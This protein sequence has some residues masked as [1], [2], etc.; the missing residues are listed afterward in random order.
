MASISAPMIPTMRCG[1][2]RRNPRSLVEGKR[3]SSRLQT[4]TMIPSPATTT[5]GLQLPERS[6]RQVREAYVSS[7][8]ELMFDRHTKYRVGNF[9]ETRGKFAREMKATMD[10]LVYVKK[11]WSKKC[12]AIYDEFK[13]DDDVMT[14]EYPKK[15]DAVKVASAELVD[16]VA[17]IDKWQ[18]GRTEELVAKEVAVRGCVAAVKRKA[19]GFEEIHSELKK[20]KK[21]KN[22][23]SATVKRRVNFRRDRL[24]LGF[25]ETCPDELATTFAWKLDVLQQEQEVTC[26]T[27]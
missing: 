23:T 22:T 10:A 24:R 6:R 14:Y 3:P 21:S 17:K 25:V 1:C 4:M 19:E 7:D 13:E 26:L 5:L 2:R 16:T 27:S 12:D 9:N 11:D 20:L 15:R 18:L 8:G